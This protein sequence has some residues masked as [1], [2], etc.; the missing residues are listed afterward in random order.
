MVDYSDL[1]K[2]ARHDVRICLQVTTELLLEYFAD[3]ID[4]VLTKGSAIKAWGSPIDYVPFFGDVD[5]HIKLQDDKPMLTDERDGFETA[6]EFSRR[7]E[8]EFMSRNPEHIH[9]PRTQLLHLNKLEQNPSY[10]P[11]KVEQI[12]PL[13]GTPKLKDPKPPAVV[14]K[15]DLDNLTELGEFLSGIS[16]TAIDRQGLEYWSLIRPMTWRVS[17]SP[18]WVLSQTSEDPLELWDWNRTRICAELENN[19]YSQI[20]KSYRSYYMSAWAVFLSSFTDRNAF[21]ECTTY[22]YRV[23]RECYDASKE[24]AA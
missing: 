8:Q 10:I 3:R 4:Y 21:R 15:V 14:K 17:P 2:K 11:P 9:V 24:F 22:A 6:Q 19:G 20:C 13:I 7:Y 12:R 18:I 5:V 23:L 1:H 16:M